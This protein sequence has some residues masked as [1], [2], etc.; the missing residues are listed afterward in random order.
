MQSQT[1]PKTN[2]QFVY[3]SLIFSFYCYSYTIFR[4]KQSIKKQSDS[5]KLEKN[6][7]K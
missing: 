1:K 4:M 7:N 3:Q 2:D 5:L 6:E